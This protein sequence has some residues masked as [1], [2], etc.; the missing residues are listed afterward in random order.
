VGKFGAA[1]G[2]IVDLTARHEQHESE[3]ARGYHQGKDAPK[4]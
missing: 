4:A 2:V 3:N 1:I